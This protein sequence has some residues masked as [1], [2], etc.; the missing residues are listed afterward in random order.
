[1][2]YTDMQTSSWIQAD[3]DHTQVQIA[4]EDSK[5]S[6]LTQCVSHSAKRLTGT[7]QSAAVCCSLVLVA[8]MMQTSFQ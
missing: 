3:V 7:V 8:V 6:M 1:M 2:L 4:D 5:E